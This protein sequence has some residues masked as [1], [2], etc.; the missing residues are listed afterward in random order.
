MQIFS[1]RSR[2]STGERIFQVCNLAWLLFF[3]FTT[4]YPFIYFIAC[5]FNEGADLMRGGVYFFPRKFT[6][7]NY[8][9]AFR[10]KN[11]VSAFS[12]S[13]FHT[14][15]G[16][17]LS[18]F[19]TSLVGYSMTYKQ[20]PGRTLLILAIYLPGWLGAALRF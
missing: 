11:I 5:S 9:T 4:L 13:I 16:T 17:I 20:M 14:V 10:N 8:M 15:V 19:V 7:E 6:L 2:L 3:A 18:L 1:K 12:V